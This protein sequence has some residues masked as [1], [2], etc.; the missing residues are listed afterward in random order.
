MGSKADSNAAD[1]E[2]RSRLFWSLSFLDTFYG[3]PTLVPSIPDDIASPCFSI[4]EPMRRSIPCPP[5]P[6]DSPNSTDGDLSHVWSHCV[7]VCGLWASVRNYVSKCI[8]GLTEAP[9]RPNSDYVKL[10]SHLLDFESTHP[11]SLSYNAVKFSEREPQAI[12]EGRADWLPWIRMQITYHAIHCVL[13]H[14]FLYSF[15]S[16]Q[17]TS[18]TNTFWRASSEKALRHCT[19]ISR[20]LRVARDKSLKLTDPFFAQAAAIAATLHLYWT[21]ASDHQ[22]RASAVSNLEV[23]QKLLADMALQ[24]SVCKQT[25][26]RLFDRTEHVFCL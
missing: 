17:N 26:I 12:L 7:R 10:C 8:E 18:G 3:P 14:P 16:A 9:W 22:L 19:W 1:S 11:V 13:N 5:L 4:S 24:W 15:G 2:E 23:C 25:V 6:E 20:L 21:H